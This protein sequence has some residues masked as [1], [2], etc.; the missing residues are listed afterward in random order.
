MSLYDASGKF[1]GAQP[2]A[3][4]KG[5]PTSGGLYD[6][7]GKLAGGV[8]QSAAPVPVNPM[9][10]VS[11][12]L[13]KVA[14]SIGEAA[15]Q[16]NNALTGNSGT[17]LDYVNPIG[18]VTKG[19]GAAAGALGSGVEK[20]A[21]FMGN[22]IGT[23]LRNKVGAPTA[24]AIGTKLK[25]VNDSPLS[26]AIGKTYGPGSDVAAGL[27]AVGNVANLAGTVAGAK[28]A[29]ESLPKLAESPLAQKVG[30]M[31]SRVPTDETALNST[32]DQNY[33]K[34]VKPSVAG[35]S[36]Q[37]QVTSYNT[38]AQNAVKSIVANK[39][40]LSLTNADG[41]TQTGALP[42]TRQQFSDAIAQTK[43]SIFEKYDALQAKAGTN[44]AAVDLNPVAN[45]LDSII[46]SK[47][48]QI[49]NPSAVDYASNLKD[50]LTSQGS[51]DTATAQDLIKNY[52]D[53]LN[54]FYRNPSPTDVH[55]NAIDS[56]VAGK[57]RSQ[58]DSVI[59]GSTGEEYQP[60]KNAYGDLK[61]IEK[62]VTKSALRGAN[63]QPK[64]L[65]DFSNLASGAELARAL[66]TLNPADFAGSAA[67]KLMSMYYK[68]LNNPD[69][70]IAS[71]FNKADSYYQGQ[72]PLSLSSK[73]AVA[74]PKTIIPKNTI[75]KK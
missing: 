32:I 14:V 18:L 6:S 56:F 39:D 53:K 7:S 1:N 3:A 75:N 24:D 74:V 72:P 26:Q 41:E 47:A 46:N 69:T 66:F 13:G 22:N 36:T 59:S 35:K 37:S 62:D 11:N 65:L 29:L 15:R 67:I 71:M 64:G 23:Y 16:T 33:A 4:P 61:T 73:S 12:P 5:P 28:G 42:Q 9:P 10:A 40:N 60:L 2:L 68:Y 43:K 54:A 21:G 55:T 30:Q 34:A 19:I 70:S 45:E 63:Q 58:L 51:L 52:N 44:G 50:R 57:L 8:P 20:A 27:G 38:S 17:P 31:F 25:A 49:S 48:L